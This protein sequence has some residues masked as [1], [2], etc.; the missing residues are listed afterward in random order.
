MVLSAGQLGLVYFPL[1]SNRRHFRVLMTRKESVVK[2]QPHDG[3]KRGV[4]EMAPP[5]HHAQW[6][7]ARR[8]SGKVMT[9]DVYNAPLTRRVPAKE[10]QWRLQIS[11]DFSSHYQNQFHSIAIPSP[12]PGPPGATPFRPRRAHTSAAVAAIVVV[13]S[14]VTFRNVNGIHRKSQNI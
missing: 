12:P 4:S 9:V 1:P 2:I 5:L 8:R 14:S 10:P 7:R 11:R 3:T 6:L 13:L